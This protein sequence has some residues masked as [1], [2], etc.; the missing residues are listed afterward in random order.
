ML[1]THSQVAIP[2]LAQNQV[3]H[4]RQQNYELG[5]F[6]TQ[7]VVTDLVVQEYSKR[8]WKLHKDPEPPKRVFQVR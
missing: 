5:R 4:E 7:E 3:A 8:A 6:G 1:T 2:S